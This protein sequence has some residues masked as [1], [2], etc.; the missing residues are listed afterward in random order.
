MVCRGFNEVGLNAASQGRRLASTQRPTAPFARHTTS[1]SW[2]KELCSHPAGSPRSSTSGWG[3][4]DLSGGTADTAPQKNTAPAGLRAESLTE[5][6]VV[7]IS[8]FK[9]S[10]RNQI[11]Y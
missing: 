9:G 5:V 11:C 8:E 7:V 1:Q 10:G 2:E 4:I 3:G 6:E